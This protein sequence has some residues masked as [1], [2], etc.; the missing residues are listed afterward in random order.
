MKTDLQPD[1]IGNQLLL[2]KPPHKIEIRF[3]SSR[4]SDFNLLE[5]ALDQRL[6]EDGFLFDGHWV[7][8]SLVS[9]SQIRGQPDRSLFDDLGRPL[10]VG[11]VER[12]V[13]F[14]FY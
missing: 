13:W 7:R 5:S 10:S 9:I 4:I 3:A 2:N 6:E 8:K 14:I 12:G 11:E 1:I